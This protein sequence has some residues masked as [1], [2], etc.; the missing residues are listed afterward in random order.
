MMSFEA[1]DEDEAE[2]DPTGYHVDYAFREKEL[3]FIERQRGNSENFLFPFG[4]KF[5]NDEDMEEGRAIV[6]ALMTEDD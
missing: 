1:D 2:E 5:N 4:L 3:E 6:K